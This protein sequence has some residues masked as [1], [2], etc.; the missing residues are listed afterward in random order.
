M[1]RGRKWKENRSEKIIRQIQ[2][3]EV[4]QALFK[5]ERDLLNITP[6]NNRRIDN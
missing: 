2:S 1:R 5:F 3:K 4:T 6:A